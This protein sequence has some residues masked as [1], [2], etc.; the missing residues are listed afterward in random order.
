M[1]PANCQPT[2]LPA[3]DVDDEGEEHDALPAAQVGEVGDP[4]LVRAVG[5]EVA[6]DE[7]RAARAWGRASWC[8]TACRGAWRPGCRAR[9][10]AAGRGSAATCSPARA[11]PSTSA[12]SRRRSSWPRAA[13]GSGRA[14]AR[15][16][17]RAR[18]A[19]GCALVVG[20]RRHAQG[21]A[22]RLDPEAAAML[23][24]VAAH[25]GRSGSSSFAKN[26]RRRLQDLV[27]AAQLVVLLAQPL[28]LLALLAGRQIRPQTLSAS[29]WRTRLRNV[30]GGCPSQRRRARS[31]GRSRTPA[32]RRARAAPPGTSSVSP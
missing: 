11:A 22:D 17:P 15:P 26:T 1:W 13:R 32:A 20:G 31:G 30:S 8:A 10:S 2:I 16:R 28:D 14:A 29:A 7:V 12:G 19:A 3:V 25:F 21:P 5:G 24:D 18:S 27:R 6:L 23:V 4:E 9:A